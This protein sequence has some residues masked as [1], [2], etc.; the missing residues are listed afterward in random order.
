VTGCD[1]GSSGRFVVLVVMD[2]VR[3]DALGCYGAEHNTT[4]SID[5]V[6]VDG[7]RFARA[8]SASGWT[9]PAVASLLSGTWPSIHGALGRGVTLSPVRPE[10]TMAAEVM[11]SAGYRTAA[12][13]NAA[14][15]SP[16]LGIDR[17]FDLFDHVYAF[18]RSTRR[19]DETVD[20][21]IGFVREHRG[22]DCFVMVHLFD[23][24]LDYDPPG[25]FAHR[26]TGSR[27]TPA[28]P[29]S[30]EAVVDM[31]GQDESPPSPADSQY[32]H[33]VYLGEVAFM[34]LHIGRL[35]EEL[36]SLGLYER[37]MIVVTADHGEEF[38]DHGGFEHGHTLY[39]ELVN[40]PL[41]IKFPSDLHPST[42][43]V[44]WQVRTIDVMPT[45][46]DYLAIQ[47]PPGFVGESLL[48]FVRAEPPGHRK[49]LSESLLYGSR[50]IAWRT[51][52]YCYVQDIEEGRE[53]IGELYNLGDDPKERV[54]LSAELP[55]VAEQMRRDCMETYLELLARAKSMSPLETIE[56][57]PL[58][59]QK[60]K[61]LGYIR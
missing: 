27:T 43:L 10:I 60:L 13:A 41:V 15:V 11:K 42:R 58:E 24:H 37:S 55:D 52:G 50:R 14:F 39:D 32:V 47:T 33:D 35:V 45:V 34:D 7:V 16:K 30:I 22:E 23:P 19:A 31:Q 46:F 18:N 25:E 21:A 2:T 57:S 28:P 17:G 54:D 48:P 61:S 9:L 56:M 4:P 38:W 51:A 53:E 12:Y 1:R 20:A 29:L 40:V 59:V 36:K 44:K 49:A 6:A 26:F 5:A 3:R 8:V